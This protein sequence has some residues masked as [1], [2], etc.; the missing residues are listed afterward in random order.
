MSRAFDRRARECART[1]RTK[2]HAMLSRAPTAP[3][4]AARAATTTK[5]RAR[6]GVEIR[7]T[8]DDEARA[9]ADGAIGGRRSAV[10]GVAATLAAIASAPSARAVPG[11][12]EE[13]LQKRRREEAKATERMDTFY[14]G[15]REEEA[16]AIELRRLREGEAQGELD[17]LREQEEAKSR[18]QVLTGKTLCVTPFGV[19]IVGITEFVA[20]AG[21]VASGISANRK[22]EEITELNEKLR[23]INASLTMSSRPVKGEGVVAE[24]VGGGSPEV[25]SVALGNTE[26]WETLSDEMKE[27]R[28]ALRDGRDLLRE[29]N[30]KGAMNAFKKSLML[31]RVVGDLVY[32][33]RATRGLGAS[34]RL[35]GDRQGAIEEFQ[36]VLTI[37][38]QL[39]D[40][41]GDMEA[42]GAIAD[43][44]TE[45][46]DLENA[47]RYYDMYLNQIDADGS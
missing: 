43:I 34:K 37:S 44:Y 24:A 26:E 47:G 30:A 27:L 7:A 4:V 25:S 12:G 11:P 20:L 23:K 35:I 29:E 18:E 19:D 32:L 38:Q 40:T 28:T 15:L 45:L 5:P 17:R 33:R 9:R 41:T 36:Q 8:S 2:T 14:R 21:A 22:K 39:E 13:L 10:I 42:L 31:A 46:G 6:R 1:A 3:A 16:K